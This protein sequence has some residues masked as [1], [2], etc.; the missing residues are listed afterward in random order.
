MSG[1]MRL[2][3]KPTFFAAVAVLAVSVFSQQ[4]WASGATVVSTDS[5]APL[6]ARPVLTLN[7][8]LTSAITLTL[9]GK[10]TAPASTISNGVDSSTAGGTG[11]V[12]FGSMNTTCVPKTS[13]GGVCVRLSSNVGARMYATIDATVTVAGV[14]SG[15]ANLGIQAP[16]AVAPLTERYYRVCGVLPA[17]PCDATQSDTYWADPNCLGASC[18]AIPTTTLGNE[19]TPAPVSSGQTVEH[20]IALEIR[21]VTPAG[22]SSISVTY[23]ATP[24]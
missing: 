12:N 2:A 9:Q 1:M 6:D 3:L 13:S 16:A 7:L 19:L 21:D 11:D 8:T 23:S 4:A 5:V 14:A 10:I 20:Q 15:T 18:T 24:S 22:A 17:S